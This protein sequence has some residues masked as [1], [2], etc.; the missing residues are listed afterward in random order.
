[1]S[2]G[3]MA[4]ESDL[5]KG[6]QQVLLAGNLCCLL[7]WSQPAVVSAALWLQVI[8]TVQTTIDAV[9]DDRQRPWQQTAVVI[10]T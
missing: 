1:M 4:R 5:F 3:I 10:W 9:K 8:T 6:P 2:A 7:V